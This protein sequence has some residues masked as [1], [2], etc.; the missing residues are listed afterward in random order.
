MGVI[1]TTKPELAIAI[2]VKPSHPLPHPLVDVTHQCLQAGGRGS[3]VEL[4]TPR[5]GGQVTGA[6]ATP[7]RIT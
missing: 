3:A 1:P 2:D 5:I 7:I 6:G 4:A